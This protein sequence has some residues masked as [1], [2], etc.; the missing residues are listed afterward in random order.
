MT[1]PLLSIVVPAKDQAPFIRDTMT[2]L[3]HQFDDP[4]ALEVIVVDD[5]SRD[6]TGELVEAFADRLPGLEILRNQEARGL[7]TA[8][9]Q[10]LEA[11][12]GTTVA[13]LDGDD[14]LAPGHL[15]ACLAA[16]D[17]LDVDFLRVDHIRVTDGRRTIHRAPQ[18]RRDTVLDPRASI[19]PETG[20]TLVDYPYAWAGIFHR[21]LADAGLLHFPDGLFTAEDRPWIWRLHLNAESFAVI[22]SPGVLYRRGVATSLTQIQDRRQLDFARAFALAFEVVAADRDS[23]TYWPKVIRQFMAVCCHHLSRSAGMTAAVKSE[24]EAAITRTRA[25]A[26]RGMLMAALDGLEARRGALLLPLL[27]ANTSTTPPPEGAR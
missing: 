6:G 26:P 12:T 22:E 2:S 19:L 14:W 11:A 10:G 25:A 24:L 9:N 1:T 7:A 23:P 5:G 13:F 20:T 15:P 18:A 16:R 8:R 4:R 17:R 21:R 27:P 3:E